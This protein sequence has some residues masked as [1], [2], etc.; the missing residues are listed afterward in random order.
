MVLT[1]CWCLITIANAISFF[2]LT[3]ISRWQLM[4]DDC[5]H[6][7][8]M[9]TNSYAVNTRFEVNS[10]RLAVDVL[11]ESGFNLK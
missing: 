11:N 6:N 1:S 7:L 4:V 10:K 8:F 5:W 9:V 2:Y 3:P